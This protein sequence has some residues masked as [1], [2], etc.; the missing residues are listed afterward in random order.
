MYQPEDQGGYY[1]SIPASI[2]NNLVDRSGWGLRQDGTPKGYGWLGVLPNREGGVSTEITT[3]VDGVAMPTLVPTLN[4]VEINHMLNTPQHIDPFS[5]K[6]GQGILSKAIEHA[7]LRM[8]LGLS[9]FK[10]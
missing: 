9:P 1:Q 2:P 6:I 10:D 3:D 4:P 5:S 7:Q 8:A